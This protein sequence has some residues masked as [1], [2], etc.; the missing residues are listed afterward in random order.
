MDIISSSSGKVSLK[1]IQDAFK[2]DR[3][4]FDRRE[5][6]SSETG[7]FIK[8]HTMDWLYE[9][10]KVRSGETI[11]ETRRVYV[12]IYYNDQLATDDKMR[13][14]KMLD[15]LEEEIIS[16]KRKVDHEKS[17]TKYFDVKETPV[18]G[19]RIKPK[20]TAINA[21]RKNFGFFVLLSN[22][23][24]DPVEAL[25]IYRT[26]DMIE[27]AFN[28]LKDQLNMRRMSVSS[29]ENLGGKLFP[30]LIALLYL[31]YVKQAMDKAGL[32]K[33]YTMQEPFDELDVIELLQQP[34]SAAYY[35]EM[36]DKQRK[37]YI[38]LEV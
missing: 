30:Q 34:G 8:S 28:D 16:G 11:N 25:K 22:D 10:V 9:D 32:F 18:R 15:A 31:S 19:A 24:K 20:Q 7:L 27:K 17:Y 37:L 29:E 1:F 23:V 3:T 4:D 13:F 2:P 12:H 38:A 35:G 21:A 6:Y 5:N 33:Y 36:T 14:T 26:K